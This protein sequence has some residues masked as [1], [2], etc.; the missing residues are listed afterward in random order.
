[1]KKHA[2]IVA[3]GKGLRM[4]AGLPK[5]FIAIKE[6][7]ILMHTIEAFHNYDPHLQLIVVL[8]EE[9]ISFWKELCST[10]AFFINHEIATGGETRF[11]SVR[12]GLKKIT[13]N[14]W[15]AVHDGVRPFASAETIGNCF[16]IASETGNA[17][18]ATELTD[19]V[20]EVANDRNFSVNRAKYKLIQTPQVF[21]VKKLKDAYETAAAT[22]KTDFTDDAGVFEFSG[23]KINLVEGNRENIKITTAFDLIVAEAMLELN[24]KQAS[25]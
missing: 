8:P 17:V 11:D 13:E 18:P 4:N 10:H 9:D 12:N 1:M 24:S 22:D 14:G 19:S 3:G 7:P 15:V 23:H 25:V 5:Q 16:R 6:K 2:I 21:D 20:R